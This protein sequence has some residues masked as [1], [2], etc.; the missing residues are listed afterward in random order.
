MLKI[1]PEYCNDYGIHVFDVA[2]K[3]GFISGLSFLRNL[4][5]TNLEYGIYSAAR[6]GKIQIMKLLKRWGALFTGSDE[7]YIRNTVMG[8]AAWHDNIRVMKLVHSWGTIDPRDTLLD[9]TKHGKI[10]AMRLARIWGAK[11]FDVAIT[12][13]VSHNQLE[14]VKILAR[15]VIDQ[16]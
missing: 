12:R 14:A 16:K 10:R 5:N 4:P 11:N 8:F 6:Y 15:W 7:Y 1:M 13:A 2:A 3:F 9:A